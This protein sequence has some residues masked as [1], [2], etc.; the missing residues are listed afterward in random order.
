[1]EKIE[2]K[3]RKLRLPLILAILVSGLYAAFYII[4]TKH[5]KSL[6][7]KS[8]E[9]TWLPIAI[10]GDKHILSGCGSAAFHLKKLTVDNIKS[11]GLTF[12]SN[13]IQVSSWQIFDK[14]RREKQYHW[15][16]TPLPDSFF[17]DGWRFGCDS[18]FSKTRKHAIV[19]KSQVK[20]S[21][22]T[23]INES[24]WLLVLPDLEMV[25]YIYYE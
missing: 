25:M 24:G 12:F 23:N 3:K 5:Y 14:N 17:A 20:G 18:S 8:I 7:P 19:E 6:I 10:D 4:E 1:M 16:E 22:Y 21:Y 2:D 11:N 13:A 9:T 15:Q